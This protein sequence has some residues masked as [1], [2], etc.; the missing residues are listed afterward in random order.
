MRFAGV[1]AGT[2][3]DA[4]ALDPGKPVEHQIAGGETHTYR[5]TL[6]AGQYLRVI[7]EQRSND[8][9]MTLYAPDERRLGEYDCRWSGA[10]PVSVIAGASGSYRLT[11]GALRKAA[12]RGAYQIRIEEARESL[13]QDN[14][15]L[16]AEKA[17]TEAKR[18]IDQGTAQPLRSAKERLD[19]ALPLWQSIG[20]RSLEAQTLNSLGFLHERFSEPRLALER[21]QQALQLRRAVNDRYGEGETLHN[22]A[23]AY[24]ALGDLKKA[25][26]V[27]QEAIN[28]RNALGDRVGVAMIITLRRSHSSARRAVVAGKLSRCTTSARF[29]ILPATGGKPTIFFLNRSPSGRRWA[30]AVANRRP[31]HI[32]RALNATVRL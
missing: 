16:V 30:T 5:I 14:A 23:A 8:L 7:V 2:R 24:S 25:I 27:Y 11:V 12:T 17:S 31:A 13:P 10:E 32:W 26:E 21:Y 6:A 15:R 19:T 3:Q 1:S 29:L 18:L 28:V 4:V 22:I 20:D 9:I